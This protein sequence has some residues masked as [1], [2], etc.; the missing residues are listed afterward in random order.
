MPRTIGLI[1]AG[2]IANAHLPA[3]LD[4]GFHVLVHS[5]ADDAPALVARHGGGRV[6][7]S[8]DSLLAEAD[9]VD[10]CTPTH[11]HHGLALRALQHRRPTICEKPLT[12]TI[13]EAED[14][15]AAF[16]V[17]EVPL[18]AAHVVRYFAEYAALR[19]AVAAGEIGEPGVLR[20]T[21]QGR[22]PES[23]WYRDDELSGGVVLD[24][25]IHDIDVVRWIAGDVVSVFARTGLV[26][27]TQSTQA[28]LSHASGAI[29][30]LT[31]TWTM[32]PIPFRTRFDVAGSA[33]VLS[34]DSDARSSFSLL[35][36]E[37]DADVLLPRFDALTSPYRAELAD[38][39]TE[40]D[41]GPTARVRAVDG[42]EAMRI[43]DAITQSA[44]TGRPVSFA[45]TRME[46]AVS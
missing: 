17:A 34:G 2:G 4:L 8:L 24:L 10:V 28:F 9:I 40:I 1:G 43:A 18:F 14:L 21:R 41:G 45:P 23:G 7:D 44:R 29:S 12:R 11:T 30:H 13:A 20:F 3:W 5:A 26:G 33:G 19:D 46:S 39:V 15:V 38:F 27:R 31:A 6:V 35:A 25:M 16:A 42:L 32:A 37:G 36:P 22:S